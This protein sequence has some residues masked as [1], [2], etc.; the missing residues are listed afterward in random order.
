MTNPTISATVFAK[1]HAKEYPDFQSYAEFAKSKGYKN[2]KTMQ[3]FY[4]QYRRQE[5]SLN[6]RIDEAIKTLTELKQTLNL[7]EKIA[8]R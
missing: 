5:S 6:V 7:L 1:K 4:Y 8:R 2:E 3:K